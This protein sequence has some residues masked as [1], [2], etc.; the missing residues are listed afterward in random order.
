[1]IILIEGPDGAG[2]STLSTKL[3]NIYECEYIH[4]SIV[5]N[6]E[7]YYNQ[8]IS[9]IKIIKNQNKNL[10]IDRASIS[11]K[12]YTSIFKD[13]DLLSNKTKEEFES[14]VDLIIYCLPY[15]KE[16]YL[17]RFEQLKGKRKEK[18]QQMEKVYDEFKKEY[19]NSTSNNKVVRYDYKYN[20]IQTIIAYIEK[21]NNIDGKNWICFFSQTGSEINEVSKKLHREPSLI[22]TNSLF[23]SKFNKELIERFKDKIVFIPSKPSLS[24]YNNLFLEYKDIFNN[25]FITLHGYLRIIPKELCNSFNIYNLHPGLITKY[26]EL[27]GF[28]P[29]EK[30]YKLQLPTSGSVIHK[31]IEQVDSGDILYQKEINIQNKSLDYIYSTLHDI[32]TNLWVEF[33]GGKND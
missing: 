14:S 20:S 11:N 7:Q 21:I 27:R 18:Y 28:N 29:Q 19:E 12:V 8:L 4:S 26:P 13:T 10:I 22:I 2:K 31:V 33:L 32:S 30:A 24:D 23:P 3:M 15:D 6:V 17:N 5:S 1:M 9:K 16:D 25:C